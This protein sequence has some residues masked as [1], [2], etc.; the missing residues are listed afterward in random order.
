MTGIGGS[1]S[2]GLDKA[3]N[4]WNKEKWLDRN[5]NA[6]RWLE[7]RE[8]AKIGMLKIAGNGW[9]W[10]KWWEWPDVNGWK[11]LILTRNC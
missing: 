3:G 4:S 5:G 6:V 7:W 2:T 10:P 11:L 8:V 9:K 1:G